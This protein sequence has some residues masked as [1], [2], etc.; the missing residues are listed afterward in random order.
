M[1]FLFQYNHLQTVEVSLATKISVS[2]QIK[3]LI[4]KFD[5]QITV[6]IL[7]RPSF[8]SYGL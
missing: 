5:F 2:S 7:V 8:P 1:K 4:F 3:C 6:L